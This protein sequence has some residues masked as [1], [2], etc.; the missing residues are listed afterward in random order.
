MTTSATSAR[1]SVSFPSNTAFVTYPATSP[2]IRQTSETLVL[3]GLTND[4][5]DAPARAPLVSLCC[6]PTSD[7]Q[8]PSYRKM[9]GKRTL[10]FDVGNDMRS[11]ADILIPPPA[12][13]P[14]PHLLRQRQLYMDEGHLHATLCNWDSKSELDRALIAANGMPTA[15]T[16]T[17][18]VNFSEAR[19]RSLGADLSQAF[20]KLRNELSQL[21][22]L[23]PT[24]A[25]LEHDGGGRL[26][27]HG[28]VSAD[29]DVAALRAIL[30]D[31]GGR[32]ANKRFRRYQTDI[33]PATT[34]LGWLMYMTKGLIKLPEAETAKHIYMSSSAKLLGKGHLVELRKAAERKLGI[35]PEFRGRAA[36]YTRST[37]AA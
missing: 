30:F 10:K 35:K 25:T 2:A 7:V 19:Q 5:V 24:V 13:I 28:M 4:L 9:S 32:A 34:T 36:V 3:L 12:Y 37:R 33:K 11:L 17:F 6:L 27:L 14:K 20:R 21:S 15:S 16:H 31:L 8:R 29:V 23:G 18:S 26:H 22:R 1:A